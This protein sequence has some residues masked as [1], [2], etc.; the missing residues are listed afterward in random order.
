MAIGLL[1]AGTPVKRVAQRMDV[2]P[3]AI[4]KLPG[5][6]QETGQVKDRPRTGRPRVTTPAVI[7]AQILQRLF[8]FILCSFSREVTDV[9]NFQE[10]T[11]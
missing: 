8:G 5:K 4:R 2:S 11:S 9:S 3:N 1:E 6:H 10:Y 7:K